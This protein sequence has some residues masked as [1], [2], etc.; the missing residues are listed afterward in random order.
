MGNK[1]QKTAPPVQGGAAAPRE[2]T[3]MAEKDAV[4]MKKPARNR[5]ARRAG[6]HRRPFGRLRSKRAQG[7]QPAQH[8]PKHGIPGLL[9]PAAR[10]LEPG[11]PFICDAVKYAFSGFAALI[12][13]NTAMDILCAD[14]DDRKANALRIQH[15]LPPIRC[16]AGVT[17]HSW[18]PSRYFF[19]RSPSLKASPTRS[20]TL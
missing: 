13:G 17:I 7:K 18:L 3:R 6:T 9:R 19:S 10:S 16:R 14:P 5:K 2:G 15:V 4:D 8:W 11:R 20:V 12:A 1:K